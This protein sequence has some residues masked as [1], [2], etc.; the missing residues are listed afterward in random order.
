MRR[1]GGEQQGSL[2][3]R[4]EPNATA[5]PVSI[6]G[7]AALRRSA[8]MVTQTTTGAGAYVLR[9]EPTDAEEPDVVLSG[10]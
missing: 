8:A 3:L 10:R 7:W 5:V 6:I 2:V 4:N 9:N 1:R